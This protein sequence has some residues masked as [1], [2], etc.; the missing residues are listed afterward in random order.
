MVSQGCRF[1]II[2]ILLGNSFGTQ[3]Y[4][5]HQAKL[6]L[7]DTQDRN[8][9]I[10]E[11]ITMLENLITEMD[12]EKEQDEQQMKDF[13]VWCTSQEASARQ[14]IESLQDKVSDVS[15]TLSEFNSKKGQLE[16][17]VKHLL[18]E[19]DHA[20]EQIETAT[21]K[22]TE[23]H[24]SFK[25]DQIDFDN[26]IVACKKA[27]EILKKHYGDGSPAKTERP[28]WMG[29]VQKTLKDLKVTLGAFKKLRNQPKVFSLIQQPNL[30]RYQASTGE[31]GNIVD[32]MKVLEETFEEDKQSA[33]DEENKL[34]QVYVTLMTE[35][36]DQLSTLTMERDSRQSV[37]NQVNQDIGESES[38]KS[39]LDAELVDEQTYLANVQRQCRDTQAL[40]DMRAKG[41]AEEK[42]ATQEAIKV[43][44]PQVKL[45]QTSTVNHPMPGH[46]H[47]RKGLRGGAR[48]N[49][50]ATCQKAAALLSQV[51]QATRSDM[52]ATAAAATLS[53]DSLDDV[54]ENLKGMIQRI[55]DEQSMENKHK[56]WCE[57]ELSTTRDKKEQHQG[58]A[59]ALER[60]IADTT[61]EIA[62]IK[63]RISEAE[64]SISGLDKGFD[65]ATALRE[66]ANEEFEL[67]LQNQKDAIAALN[68][69]IGM[70]A[71]TYGKGA[72]LLQVA[73]A[74]REMA[75]GVFDGVYEQKGGAGVIDMLATVRGEFE[76][77]QKL[78]EQAE[79]QEV[80]DFELVKSNYNAAR[81]DLVSTK[82]MLKAQLH[83][84]EATLEQSKEDKSSHETEVAAADQYLAQLSGSCKSLLDNFDNRVQIRKEEKNAIEEAI[85][86]LRGV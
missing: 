46:R 36:K 84:A 11:V 49:N 6:V 54:V 56:E 47:R 31:A 20:K 34:Q 65:E 63:E 25:K 28:A 61:E 12:A 13:S 62:E 21:D 82:D 29:F 30:D 80:S 7:T 4:T 3:I 1:G 57:T 17:K 73:A 78:L 71:K 35:K 32:Q 68:T 79:N 10:G 69:A 19:I 67:E 66:K 38:A 18:S 40:F 77:G 70:L 26:S 76:S 41:R 75:P 22:R 74:P 5:A 44:K 86:V 60:K 15:A 33:I 23:D 2:L 42:V 9:A 72:M 50:C 52:L 48:K 58:Q 39:M 24:D 37:L 59:S 43:L 83:T 55:A 14:S 16:I 8:D 51:A 64:A 85:S 27:V 45:L 53:T 81:N